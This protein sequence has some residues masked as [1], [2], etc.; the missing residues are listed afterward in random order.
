MGR[1]Q[2]LELADRAGAV[3]GLR[4][5]QRPLLEDEWVLGDIVGQGVDVVEQL[6]KSE[7]VAYHGQEL[8]PHE[9]PDRG[10]I[11]EPGGELSYAVLALRVRRRADRPDL[12]LELRKLG[13]GV[14]ERRGA[15]GIRVG[16]T[17]DSSEDRGDPIHQ[18][19]EAL[20]QLGTSLLRRTV[21]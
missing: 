12:G 9:V 7:I 13:D 11:A 5:R 18:A 20:P 2:L 17:G 14:G 6:L 15:L 3:A 8:D 19:C 21:R 4:Q 10:T 16:E 1:D